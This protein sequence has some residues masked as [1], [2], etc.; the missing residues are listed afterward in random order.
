M[1]LYRRDVALCR[2]EV[3]LLRG[4]T[5]MA[6]HQAI[7]RKQLIQIADNVLAQL[8]KKGDFQIVSRVLDYSSRFVL[9][10]GSEIR[11][12]M[13]TPQH[14]LGTSTALTKA[15]VGHGAL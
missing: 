3:G 8:G 14:L 9:K 4:G 11:Y 6:K 13:E 5:P 1:A 2:R 10:Y 7:A 15:L 12:L